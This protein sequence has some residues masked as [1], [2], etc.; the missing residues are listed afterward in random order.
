MMESDYSLPTNDCTAALPLSSIHD[1]DNDD[2][3]SDMG[4]ETIHTAATYLDRIRDDEDSNRRETAVDNDHTTRTSY[5]GSEGSDYSDDDGSKEGSRGS[6]SQSLGE[7]DDG[8]R[9]SG[10][11]RSRS[12]SGANNGDISK[13]SSASPIADIVNRGREDQTR[14][15]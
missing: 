15:E 8:R 2:D 14:V 12:P 3:G 13:G 5:D 4:R 11:G 1:D 7:D 6:H 9:G 10:V